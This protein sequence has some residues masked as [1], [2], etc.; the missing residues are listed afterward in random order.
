MTFKPNRISYTEPLQRL[1]TAFTPRPGDLITK[2]QIN[3]VLQLD[4]QRTRGVIWAWRKQLLRRGLKTTG[5]GKGYGI[6]IYFLT[7]REDAQDIDRLTW[8]G[9]RRQKR[10]CKRTNDVDTSEMTT[11]EKDQHELRKRWQGELMQEQVR[12][13]KSLQQQPPPVSSNVRTLVKR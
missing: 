2:V 9:A 13:A 5:G 10:L 7:G 6:G 12:V 3:A 4:E 11:A 1:D 8:L